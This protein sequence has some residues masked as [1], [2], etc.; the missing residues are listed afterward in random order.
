VPAR[1]K[2][3]TATLPL[4]VLHAFDASTPQKLEWALAAATGRARMHAGAFAA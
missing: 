4:L 3:A 2:I 1:L